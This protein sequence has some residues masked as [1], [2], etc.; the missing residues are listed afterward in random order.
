MRSGMMNKKKNDKKKK[1]NLKKSSNS[2]YKFY[3]GIFIFLLFLTFLFPYSIDDWAWGSQFGIE[4]LQSLFANYNGRWCGN[5]LAMILT[6]SRILRAFFM[7]F[8]LSFMMYL[9]NKLTSI[10]SNSRWLGI[11]L[12]VALPNLILRQ[13]VVWT[14]GFVNY[15][16]SIFLVLI[17]V[18]QNRG[19]FYDEVDK[20]TKI[21]SFLMLILGFISCLF[22]EHVTLYLVV[23]AIFVIAYKYVKYKHISAS[24]ICYFI[25]CVCGTIL[26]FCNQAY[27]NVVEGD[28]YYRAISSKSKF[29]IDAIH[30]FVDV[31]ANELIFQ[32]LLLNIVLSI[33]VIAF[34][35]NYLKKNDRYKK[36]I[37]GAILILSAFP[38]YAVTY[39]FVGIDF[40]FKYTKYLN[41]FLA[42]IYYLTIFLCSLLIK[43]VPKKKKIIFCL[44]SNAILTAPLFVVKPIGSRCFFPMYVLW[45]IVAIEF[46]TLAFEN[47]KIDVMKPIVISWIG[48]FSGFL[49]FIYGTSFIVEYQRINFVKKHIS[50][51][52]IILPKL[53]YE[54][55][56]WLGDPYNKY[57]DQHFKNYY[58][59]P[60]D[61][62]LIFV[63]V[64]E[65]KK[66]N[67]K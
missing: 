67:K 4:K 51:E 3:L 27:F 55:F 19:L 63:P 18:Y 28:D 13:A 66:G 15:V 31:I 38:I 25:G 8:I 20:E 22:I 37:N 11:L 43:D 32:N 41:S 10:D 1:N 62:N 59:V 30:S 7:A 58:G 48:I 26:M 54:D 34:L 52:E 29:I 35:R 12:L 57:S 40:L 60:Q 39:K 16:V 53:P 50:E 14:S 65:W 17:Y 9:V 6:R 49:I 2:N 5:I 47:K 21:K 24:S 23:L 44:V 42:T 61:R 45:I 56:I 46:F 64:E 36:Y 33:C